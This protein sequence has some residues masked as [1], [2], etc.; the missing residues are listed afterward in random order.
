VW[1]EQGDT[2]ELW[3]A[4]AYYQTNWFRALCVAGLIAL[5]WAAHLVR[6]R[7]VQHQFEMT[8]EA[9]VGE[10]TRIAREL[11]DTLLQGFHGLLLK[12]QTVSYLLPDRPG[13]AKERLESA[14]E[15]AAKA[16][17]EGRDAVQGLRRPA[18]EHNDLAVAITTLADELATDPTVDRPPAFHVAVEGQARDLHPIV[19]DEIYKIAA[20]A[21][22]NAFRHAR[23]ARVETEIR[24]DKREFR[25]RLRDDGQGIDAGVLAGEG[26]QGHYGLHG[27]TERAASMGGKLAVW[28]EVG[29]GTE[30]EL[31]LP[32]RVAYATPRRESWWSRLFV[33]RTPA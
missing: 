24:Y 18:L 32:A 4:P 13:D 2:L 26:V 33:P 6:V 25:L 10:R 9:R 23:A 16:I 12:F 7:Q 17:T 29:T 20:E 5:L 30:I 14:I 15:H 28:S 19:R 22:R 11:H 27:M 1:N 31:R 8:L 21:L 3:V